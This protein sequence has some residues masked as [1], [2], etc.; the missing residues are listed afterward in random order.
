M[1][2]IGIGKVCDLLGTIVIHRQAVDK[3]WYHD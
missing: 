1:T 2:Y 3:Q